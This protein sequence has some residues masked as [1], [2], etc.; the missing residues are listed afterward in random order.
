MALTRLDT[1]IDWVAYMQQIQQYINGERD[2]AM[3]KGD[4]GP[5][6]YPA[7][8]VYIYRGLY[9]ITQSGRNILL[10]QVCFS[11]LY[12]INLSLAMLCYIEAEVC[13]SPNL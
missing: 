10:A 4:T 13:P 9:E 5:L 6:V 8:H 3:I 2:Y 1:E 7:M 12:I 11:T